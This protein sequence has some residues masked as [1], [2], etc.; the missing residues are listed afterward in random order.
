MLQTG[1]P[2]PMGSLCIPPI[3]V[4]G[5]PSISTPLCLLS[6]THQMAKLRQREEGADMPLP[7][8]PVLPP[9]CKV[10]RWHTRVHMGQEVCMSRCAS[11]GWHL[12]VAL[13][14]S[15]VAVVGV[16]AGHSGAGQRGSRYWQELWVKARSVGNNLHWHLLSTA[17][18]LLKLVMLSEYMGNPN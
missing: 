8:L 13:G 11:Q 6:L 5:E 14:N 12:R 1:T 3:D 7:L 4:I 18:C 17:C 2:M 9:A 16:R 15:T 10:G